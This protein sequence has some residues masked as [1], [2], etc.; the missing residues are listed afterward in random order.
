MQINT[1]NNNHKIKN[2][3]QLHLA[4]NENSSAATRFQTLIYRKNK[5]QKKTKY[6]CNFEISINEF[7]KD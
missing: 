3:K 5:I 6:L 2:V 1:Y 4:K 7:K